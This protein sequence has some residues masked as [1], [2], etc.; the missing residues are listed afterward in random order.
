MTHVR[1]KSAKP[2]ST[3]RKMR[4]V[5]DTDISD[6]ISDIS[7]SKPPPGMPYAR[8]AKGMPA[9]RREGK[10]VAWY[11]GH[12]AGVYDAYLTVKTRYPRVAE[13]LR[14]CFGMDKEGSL[15]L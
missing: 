15:H 12:Q 13:E 2:R 7:P 6:A 3:K 8:W 14:K 10:Q 11:R 5:R 4:R 9:G 1:Q